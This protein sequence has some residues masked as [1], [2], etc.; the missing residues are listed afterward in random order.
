V[1]PPVHPGSFS[2]FCHRPQQ[3]RDELLDAGLT[4]AALVSVEGSV[5]RIRWLR[6]C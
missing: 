5:I 2:G 6:N 4:V 1:L 3:L